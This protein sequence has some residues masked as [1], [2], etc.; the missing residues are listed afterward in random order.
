[1]DRILEIDKKNLMVTVSRVSSRK[2]PSCRGAEGFLS[3][4]PASLD[5]CTIGG[6]TVRGGGPG[7]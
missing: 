2:H 4:D 3:A 1:M 7:R 5:S 6:N